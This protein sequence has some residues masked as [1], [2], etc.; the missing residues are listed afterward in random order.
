MLGEITESWHT[1][2]TMKKRQVRTDRRRDVPVSRHSH[3]FSNKQ[4]TSS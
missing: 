3:S 1:I 4:S 2:T